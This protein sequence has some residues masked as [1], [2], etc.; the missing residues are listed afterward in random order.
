VLRTRDACIQCNRDVRTTEEESLK[1][2]KFKEAEPAQHH[3]H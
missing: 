3:P 2:N 1:D